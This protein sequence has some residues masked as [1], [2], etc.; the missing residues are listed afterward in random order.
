MSTITTDPFPPGRRERKKRQTRELIAETAMNLFLERGFDRVTV[1]QVAEAADVSLQ[2]V[3]NHFRTKEDLVFG[4]LASFED[5]LL[6][7]VRDR[8]TGESVVTAFGRLLV[9]AQ[10]GLL[11]QDDPA[12]HDRLIRVNRM[13][14]GSP[15]LRRREEQVHSTRTDAL[16]ALL[17]AEGGSG[18]EP[19]VIANALIGVHRALIALAR[20]GVLEGTTPARLAAV[21]STQAKRALHLL[22]NGIGPL[23]A[24]RA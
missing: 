21:V 19:W 3:F 17:Q 22:E 16:A 18:I 20:R 11:G 1:A 24:G 8:A 5:A 7:G 23:A 10:G 15:A 9:G 6:A 2:T 14:D 12:A 13:I 4:P